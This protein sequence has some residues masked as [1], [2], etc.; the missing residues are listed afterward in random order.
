MVTGAENWQ[1]TFLSHTESRDREI[2][3]GGRDQELRQGYKFSN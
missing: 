1:I 2:D 3:R